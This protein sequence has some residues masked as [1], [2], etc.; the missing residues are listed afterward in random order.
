MGQF[1]YFGGEGSASRQVKYISVFLT[2]NEYSI[3]GQQ[4]SWM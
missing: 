4:D 1:W 3:T 2:L